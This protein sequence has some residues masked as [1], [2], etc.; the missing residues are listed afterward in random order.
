MRNAYGLRNRRVLTARVASALR[1]YA[2]VL[3]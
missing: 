1:S 3:R 2:A